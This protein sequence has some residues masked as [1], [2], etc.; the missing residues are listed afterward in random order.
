M[1]CQKCGAE[2]EQGVLF[3][4]ECG[5]KVNIEV[6]FCRECG[7]QLA[8]GVRFC[9]NC[10]ADVDDINKIDSSNIYQVKE[11][12]PE[13]K[14]DSNGWI[15]GKP[16]IDVI[17]KN[18]GDITKKIPRKTKGTIYL[19]L[20][21]LVLLIV[22]IGFKGGE[23]DS[24]TNDEKETTVVRTISQNGDYTITK[25]SQYAY[26]VDEW[27]VYV[28]TAVS[29]SL[30]KI[31]AWD[32]GSSDESSV[33]Y[34]SDVGTYKI[35]AEE[36]GFGWLDE[37]HTAFVITFKDSKSSKLKEAAPHIFTINI[38]DD[39]ENKGSDYDKTI[40]CYTYTSDDWHTY[41]AIPLTDNLI[42]IECWYKHSGFFT[43]KILYSW[44]WCIIDTS[45]SDTDF[46]W[47][48]D[49]H[50]SFTI[51]T[52]DPQ[53]SSWDEDK[54]I[55]FEIDDT[56][57]KYKTVYEYL[58]PNIT[59]NRP[60]K[61]GFDKSTNTSVQVGNYLFDIP[62]YWST[63][64]EETNKYTAYAETSGK[65]ALI[66]IACSED[67]DTVSY[68]AL[69]K[70]N[71]AGSM[72]ETISSWFDEVN[73]ISIEPYEN[74]TIKG[75]KYSVRFKQQDVNGSCKVVCIPSIEDNSWYYI[76]LAVSDNTEYVYD[77]DF[78]KILDSMSFIQKDERDEVKESSNDVQTETSEK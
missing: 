59:D 42:K 58:N 77:N 43:D 47:T 41:K 29:D 39:D 25:G 18:I 68:E 32:K 46:E 28:A 48:D 63:N 67:E 7:T 57:C 60:Q 3:C 54:F 37:E 26:M 12:S 75:S 20:A 64:T 56:N 51:T 19:V 13:N 30:I 70:E 14:K 35:N 24:K 74:G 11:D 50:T 15:G 22:M 73:N 6:K 21:L 65:T 34:D 33:N 66:Y 49:E 52:S 44:D 31:E 72:Q 36:N 17:A 71:E 8:D 10:G 62:S 53:N 45:S 1:K 23:K 4:K 5:T 78:I 76:F 2:L 9:S 55:V 27:N 61:E 16:P 38:N 40:A 69:E